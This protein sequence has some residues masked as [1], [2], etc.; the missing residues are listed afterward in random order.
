MSGDTM[1]T[2]EFN[3]FKQQP[4]LVH[5]VFTRSGGFSS[6]RFDSL[7]VG[8]NS[9]DEKSLVARNR[10]RII[11]KMGM[12][13]MIFLNQVHGDRITVLKKSGNDLSESFQPG[14]ELYT[15]DGCVTDIPGIFLV[16]QVADCQSI[17][18]HDPVQHVVANVHS[19][20]RGSI[21]NIVGHCLD[22]MIEQFGCRPDAILAG[23]SPSLGPCCAEFINYTDEI[24]QVLWRYKRADA[25]Y[26]DF[27]Q[28]TTDQL[29][30]K[31][32]TPAH[33]ENMAICTKCNTQS[34][35]SYRREKQTGRFACVIAME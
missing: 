34:F 32:V 11:Q 19:G 21:K 24:P 26:F 5:G 27:W 17:M 1:E 3:L 31:G 9:G 28:M 8:M 30:E 4:G 13:P 7:N 18:L 25:P 16:I 12:R 15:A 35:Y 33:I 23:I 2:C 14:T 20:W 29:T 10:K 6:G 22:V